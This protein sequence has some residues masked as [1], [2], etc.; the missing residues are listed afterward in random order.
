MYE[1]SLQRNR[2]DDSPLGFSRDCD[3]EVDQL[4]YNGARGTCQD[5]I[6][7]KDVFGFADRQ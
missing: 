1:S 3:H 5:M 6:Y 4:V 7:L 2:S